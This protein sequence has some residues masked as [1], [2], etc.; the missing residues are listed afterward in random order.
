MLHGI[1]RDR[2]GLIHIAARGAVK[3]HVFDQWFV[4]YDDAGRVGRGVT[5]HTF[6][7]LGCVQ[8]L[9]DVVLLVVQLLEFRDG[10]FA[11]QGS[12][13]GDGHAWDGR[14]QPRYAVNLVLG[15]V[16]GAA[17]IP[18]GSASAHSPEGDDLRDFVAAI[19]LEGVANELVPLVVREVQIDVGH[20][21][22]T[23]VQEALEDQVLG[24]GVDVCDV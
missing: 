22:T 19:L 13:D 24:E 4:G 20:G 6:E 5:R 15:Q 14:H 12:F 17:G 18:N 10:A 2:Q 1:L 9:S 3:W 16:Q 23:R 21:D 7:A 8:Q 11:F